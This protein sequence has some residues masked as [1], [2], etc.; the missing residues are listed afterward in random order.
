MLLDDIISNNVRIMVYNSIMISVVIPFFDEKRDIERSVDSILSQR[1]VSKCAEIIIVN[2]CGADSGK[3]L[4]K[5]ERKRPESILIVM[6]E[7]DCNKAALLNIGMSYI[8]GEY[9]LF[10]NPGD[11]LNRELFFNIR[12]L[13]DKKTPDII[14]YGMT[15]T[16]SAFEYF[17]Y[18]PFDK[19]SF[20]VINLEDSYKRKAFL[21]G[22]NCNEHYLCNAFNTDFLRTIGLKFSEDAPDDDVTFTYPFFFFAEKIAVTKDH[23]YCFCQDYIQGAKKVTAGERISARLSLQLKLLELLQSV[24]EIYSEYNDVIEAHF[25]YEYFLKSLEIAEASG[26][27]NAI[28]EELLQILQFVTQKIIPKWSDNDYIYSLG[29]LQIERIKYLFSKVVSGREACRELGEN[30]KVSVIIA[31]RN[32]G[33]FLGRSIECILSQTWK[34][35]EL[36]IV[37]DGSEDDTEEVVKRFSDS[38]IKYIKNE[39][40]RG[41]SYARNAG[42]KSAQGRFIVYQDDDDLCRLDKIEKQVRCMLKQPLDVG[43]AYCVTL[44]HCRAISGSKDKTPIY[45]P[46]GKKDGYNGCSGFIFPKILPKNFVACTAMIIRKECF[47]EVGG[48]DEKLFAYEDWDITLRLAKRYDVKLIPEVLYDYYQRNNGLAS[49]RNPEHR[50]ALI[51]SLHA[52]DVKYKPDMKLYGI[53]SK[54]VLTDK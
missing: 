32:R 14:S 35:L 7:E 4:E 22:D 30:G 46:D 41:V 18:E 53:E 40:N 37:N 27:E 38:R 9:L 10:L 11:E 31:T 3:R 54:F 17:E 5:L 26:E 43:M 42:L 48:F 16:L 8:N 36:I 45:I 47:D 1:N 51:E 23:G 25:F 15:R 20:S 34:N 29:R 44:N 50:R 12:R 52:I 2:G 24:P 13:S 6:P 21:S 33:K 39:T 49:N 28:S 19:E